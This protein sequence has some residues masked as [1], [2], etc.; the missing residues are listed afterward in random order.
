MRGLLI[1]LLFSFISCSS[2]QRDRIIVPELHAGFY[3]EAMERINDELKSNPDNE[4]LVDQKL[5][6]CEQLGWPTTCISALD[7]YKQKHGMTNQLVEQYIAYYNRHE[8]Y[9]LLLEL[10]ERWNEE[11][12]LDEKYVEIYIDCLT[13]LNRKELATVELRK[14]LI[15][16]QSLND[17]VF[18]SGQFLKLRDTAL[19]A[20]NLGKV[21]K[22]DSDNELMWSYGKILVRLGYQNQG[23]DILDHY[24]IDKLDQEQQVEYARLLSVNGRS[25]E[26]RK[27]LKPYT[28][29]DTIAYL[30]TDWYQKDLLWDSASFV[31]QEVIRR[32]S[33]NRKPLWKMGRLY[34]EKGWFSTSLNYF[35]YLVELDPSDTLAAQRIGLIQRK[36]AYLQRLKFEEEN[37]L[38]I[39]DLESKKI[40]N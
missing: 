39:K 38:P 18:A 17:L 15:E 11:Y 12:D 10:I 13:R 36:I 19:A 29:E 3:S 33:T 4:K 25:V 2:P 7:S 20:Y 28:S 21:Y 5:F 30:L 31:L 23:F 8:R 27:I 35:N 9:Q 6:Y 32:D 37:R 14:Y 1:I 24:V 16:H 22:M 34:E 26:A 40:E